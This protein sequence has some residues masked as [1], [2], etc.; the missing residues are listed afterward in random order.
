MK[1]ENVVEIVWTEVF[2]RVTSLTD[3]VMRG[4]IMT[5]NDDGHDKSDW[6]NDEVSDILDDH[7]QTVL[8]DRWLSAQE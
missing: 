8:P 4:L 1:T 6:R 2:I 7:I 5:D 3:E